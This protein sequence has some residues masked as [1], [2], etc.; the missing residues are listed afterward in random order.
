MPTRIATLGRERT[1][2]TLARRIYGLSGGDPAL[3]R[4]EAALLRANPR[5][6]DRGGFRSGAAIVVPNVEGLDLSVDVQAARVDA[7]GLVDETTLRLQAL[8][9]RVESGFLKADSDRAAARNL[10]SD[11]KFQS[12]A[13]DALPEASKILAATAQR[14]DREEAEDK[15]ASARLAEGVSKAI[16]AVSALHKLGSRKQQG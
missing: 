7:S 13:R 16:E 1:L 15:D 2:A 12:E 11:R 3:P 8:A 4:A 6:A 14:L 9:S 5:L 10:L